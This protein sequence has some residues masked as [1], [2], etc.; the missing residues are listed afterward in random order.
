MCF[1]DDSYRC[2]PYFINI[3]LHGYIYISLNIRII[4]ILTILIRKFEQVYLNTCLYALK[5]QDERQTVQTLI[6]R[7]ILHSAVS[8][9]CLHCLHRHLKRSFHFQSMILNKAGRVAK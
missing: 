3:I 2:A 4:P 5:V 7:R 9:L 8:A 1:R 6:R